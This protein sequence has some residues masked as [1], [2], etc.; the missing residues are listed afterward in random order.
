[1]AVLLIFNIYPQ[2]LSYAAFIFVLAVSFI[3][4]YGIL[5]RGITA[6]GCFGPLTWLNSKPWLTFLRNG[7][8]LAL[9]IPSILK[10]QR[11][12]NFSIPTIVF[13]ALI[14]I[15]VMFMCG[16]SMHGAKCLQTQQERFEPI[17]LPESKLSDLVSCT[18]DSTYMVFAFSYNCPYC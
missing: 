11:G 17:L 6:C 1:M 7:I 2:W 5:C 16:F 8:L 15:V 13:M 9:L 18:S 4:L 10:P 3:Y 12:A 14:G